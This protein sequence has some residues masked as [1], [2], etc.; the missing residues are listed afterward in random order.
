[1]SPQLCACCRYVAARQVAGEQID[2]VL[3]SDEWV[4]TKNV[5][6][7]VAG[8]MYSGAKTFINGAKEGW[9]AEQ[10]VQKQ[11]DYCDKHGLDYGV[12][13]KDSPVSSSSGVGSPQGN[14]TQASS[15]GKIGELSGKQKITA[16]SNGDTVLEPPPRHSGWYSRH[17]A[18]MLLLHS[19]LRPI[20]I[21]LF[22]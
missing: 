17:A 8:G 4:K 19:Y 13:F 7:S 5:T 20:S 18:M 9:S 11:H 14:V 12:T 6:G 1:M 21:L 16:T 15:R 22:F 3:Q 2:G 10:Q